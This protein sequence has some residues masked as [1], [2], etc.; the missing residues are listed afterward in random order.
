LDTVLQTPTGDQ[1]RL[2]VEGASEPISRTRDTLGKVNADGDVEVPYIVMEFLEGKTLA[3]LLTERSQLSTEE[4]VDLLLPV[5]SALSAAHDEGIVHRDVK[6]ANIFLVE[7]KKGEIIPKVLDFGIAKLIER[8]EDLT[9]DESFIGT[10]EYMS[11]EQGRGERDLDPRADQFSSAAILYHCMTGHKLYTSG[12]LIGLVRK[13]SEGMYD[14]PST[15][16]PELPDGLEEVVLRALDRD[17]DR[18]YQSVVSFGKAL[19]PFASERARREWQDK[20]TAPTDP[21]PPARPRLTGKSVDP[22]A[23][24]VAPPASSQ[25]ASVNTTARGRAHKETPKAPEQPPMWMWVALLGI[26]S[27]LGWAALSLGL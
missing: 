7:N 1:K 25:P 24:T 17:R 12:S 21:P 26:L 2:A 4:A 16:A 6:P 14:P 18:R 5:L 13:V 22:T 23:P 11:P 15:F 27:A 10:P 9:V 3:G 19:L 8:S 20:L